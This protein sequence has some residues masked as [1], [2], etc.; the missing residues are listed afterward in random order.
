MSD[1]TTP[2]AGGQHNVLLPI[3]AVSEILYCPKNFWLRMAD[4]ADDAN[5]PLVR[6]SLADEARG[7][8]PAYREGGVRQQ[9]QADVTSVT[10]GIT[11][12]VDI[13]EEAGGVWPVE[14]K[15]GRDRHG[16][17]EEVQLCAYGM[18][19]E[20]TLA[21]AVPCGY[22]YHAASGR[23]RK[24]EFS[25]ELR[26][27]VAD[28][29]IRARE[30]L[31]RSE[32]PEGVADARC[33]GCALFMRCMP[34][35]QEGGHVTED[36]ARVLGERAEGQS[37]V[38]DRPGAWLRKEGE[39]FLV[40]ADH[41]RLAEVS[42]HKVD[43]V[44]LV[45]AVTAS[46]AAVRLAWDQGIIVHHLSPTGVYLGAYVP[47]SAS[48]VAVRRMQSR[49]ADDPAR[50]QSVACA[51]VR[52][53]LHNQKTLLTRWARESDAQTAQELR[54]ASQV[55]AQTRK[56]LDRCRDGDEL[57]GLEGFAAR[58]YFAGVRA[59]LRA[60]ELAEE[61]RFEHRNRRPPRD[62]V[63]ATLSFGYALLLRDCVS[64]CHVAGLDPYIGLFHADAWSRPSMALDLCEE[65]RPVLVDR[66]VVALFLRRILKPLRDF[67]EVPGGWH[68]TGPGRSA[69]YAAYDAQRRQTLAHPLFGFS[70][71]YRRCVEIQAR[72]LAKTVLG[73]EPVYRPFLLRS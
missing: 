17:W 64:A 36:P 45:G 33:S 57:R 62:P 20:E 52:G 46:T 31:S 41:E 23:R 37:L 44:T 29:V 42:A 40:S 11:G 39:R 15:S 18:A 27:L 14:Y 12:K 7:Q 66:L 61:V 32:P 6:G 71:S 34:W 9:R 13:V 25:Q 21:V 59:R 56:G 60:A 35:L 10:L 19:L 38:V 4:H 69:F 70:A 24:V 58:T 67:T 73:E 48:G 16:R 1:I 47:G 68:L 53:K 30:L 51:I 8:A 50:A 72:L 54:A 22:L 5:A 55:I 2:D 28:T 65:F 43:S 49:V 3:S 63:N 26:Q